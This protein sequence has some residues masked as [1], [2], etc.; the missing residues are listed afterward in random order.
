MAALTPWPG[1]GT[2]RKEMDRL[3]DRFWEGDF[4]ALP[5]FGEWSPALDVSETKD[6]LVVKVE[7]PGMDPGDIQLSLHENTLTIKGEKKHEKEEKSEHV[8]RAE[9]SY[10][11][12]ARAI[13]LPASV[14]S[15]KVAASF[16]NGLLTVTLPKAPAAKGSV[17]PIKA[18]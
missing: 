14:D 3:F 4:P 2:L 9:R 17:I 13:R 16:K 15:E 12:F 1:F 8:Y 10:G 18:E 7:V 5:G 6:A 11:A